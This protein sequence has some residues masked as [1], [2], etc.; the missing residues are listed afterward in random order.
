MITPVSDRNFELLGLKRYETILAAISHVL[1]ET[2]TVHILLNNL[3]PRKT[4]LD[5]LKRFLEASPHFTLMQTILRR[6]SDYDKSTGVGKSVVEFDKTSKA[7][8]EIKALVKEV[9]DILYI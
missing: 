8:K 7:A 9:E 2:V 4:R 5:D 3:D 6:R 1:E